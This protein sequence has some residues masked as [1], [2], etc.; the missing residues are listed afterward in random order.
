MFF[1]GY[2]LLN[3]ESLIILDLIPEELNLECLVINRGSY[4][5]CNYSFKNDIY[6]KNNNLIDLNYIKMIFRDKFIMNQIN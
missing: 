1:N 4:V 6:D 5:D 2:T 3:S